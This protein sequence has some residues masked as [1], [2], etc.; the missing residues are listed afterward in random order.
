M[1]LRQNVPGSATGG[2]QAIPELRFSED[3]PLWRSNLLRHGNDVA[4]TRVLSH[5]GLTVDAIPDMEQR[6]HNQFA[7]VS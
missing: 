7:G 6:L 1:S 3:A 4:I 5:I 2:D